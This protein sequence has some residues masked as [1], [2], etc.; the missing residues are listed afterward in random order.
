MKKKYIY[1][2]VLTNEEYGLF[3][4]EIM[5]QAKM[6]FDALIFPPFTFESNI[7]KSEKIAKDIEKYQYNLLDSIGVKQISVR[8]IYK[9]ITNDYKKLF[10][11]A[12]SWMK[13]SNN[14]YMVAADLF[15]ETNQSKERLVPP[16]TF[17][18]RGWIP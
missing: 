7:K 5:S 15:R 10:D 4:T 18:P 16:V 6:I 12:S 2:I 17:T 11:N 14:D 1:V 3:Y 13:K 9:D 8:N